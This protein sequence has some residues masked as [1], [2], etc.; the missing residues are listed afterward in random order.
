MKLENND[1]AE[2]IYNKDSHLS[3]MCQKTEILFVNA[4]SFSTTVD[5][6]R[7]ACASLELDQSCGCSVGDEAQRC[8][9]V[10]CHH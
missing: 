8:D 9:D 1:L 10:V 5:H 3:P 6:P 2:L 4:K 7:V